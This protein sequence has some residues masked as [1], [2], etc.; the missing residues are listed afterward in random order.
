MKLL[1]EA[2]Y[3]SLC[4][5]AAEIVGAVVREKSSAS[6]IVA[7]GATPMGVYDRLAE[8]RRKGTFA[9]DRLTV[10]QLDEYCG[11]A[12]D[13]PRSLYGW[14]CRSF[15]RPL[16]VSESNVVRLHCDGEDGVTVCREYDDEVLRRGGID[17]AILGLGPNGHLGFNEPPSER[18]APTRS[19]ALTPASIRSNASYWGSPEDV[20]RRAVTAGMTVLLSARSILLLISGRH[21]T[22]IMRQVLSGPIGPDVPASFLREVAG[23][24]V[25]ADRDAAGD[26]GSL[27]WG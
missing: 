10:F 7:T 3:E 23:A 12:D 9:A 17:L 25:L 20:P 21:K 18:S 5:K 1:V 19:V 22:D 13:D 26:S 4:R 16:G 15:V 24:I 6:L 8:E 14:M 11:I 2:D 27:S